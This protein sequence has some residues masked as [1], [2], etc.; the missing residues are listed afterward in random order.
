[1]PHFGGGVRTGEGGAQCGSIEFPVG[2]AR[3][4]LAYHDALRHHVARQMRDTPGMKR[5]SIEIRGGRHDQQND[6]FAEFIVSD[7]EGNR[8]RDQTTVVND[9]FDFFRADAIPGALDLRVVARDEV[10]ESFRVSPY[11]IT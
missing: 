4:C 2:V 3:N 8:F 9:F 11:Q 5:L 1:M 6:S 7:A 10:Q